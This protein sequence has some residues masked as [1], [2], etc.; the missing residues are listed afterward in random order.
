[1]KDS[2]GDTDRVDKLIQEY[3][4]KI[5]PQLDEIMQHHQASETTLDNL[6]RWVADNPEEYEELLKKSQCAVESLCVTIAM[7]DLQCLEFR[8][9]LE[10]AL[11]AGLSLGYYLGKKAMPTPGIK[12]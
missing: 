4:E 3:R 6:S 1:M 9:L 12:L 10:Q 5:R 11:N 7:Y 8:E 2:Q